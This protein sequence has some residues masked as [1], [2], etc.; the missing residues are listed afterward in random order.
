MKDLL[1]YS[2]EASLAAYLTRVSAEEYLDKR[3]VMD[4]ILFALDYLLE[5]VKGNA[6]KIQAEELLTAAYTLNADRKVG[7]AISKVAHA[8]QILKLII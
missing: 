4:S 2:D 5:G 6:L 7:P 1:E 3:E 8:I